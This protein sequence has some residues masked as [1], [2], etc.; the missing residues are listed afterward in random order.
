MKDLIK[1]YN[2]LYGQNYK[3]FNQKDIA[4]NNV[5]KDINI[6]QSVIDHSTKNGVCFGVVVY[7]ILRRLKGKEAK[8]FKRGSS[9]RGFSNRIIEM[10]AINYGW[11]EKR[12]ERCLSL[13][14]GQQDL[15]FLDITFHERD[16]AIG[17]G[18]FRDNLEEAVENTVLGYQNRDRQEERIYYI[19][20]T[21]VK[22]SGLTSERV[23]HAIAIHYRPDAFDGYNFRLIDANQGELRYTSLTHLIWH[24]LRQARKFNNTGRKRDKFNSIVWSRFSL[25]SLRIP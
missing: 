7:Y 23:G 14:L 1:Y 20:I 25:A 22:K 4:K 13:G 6:S 15:R 3:A 9:E 18:V 11:D 21:G 19:D 16:K 12:L 10:Q 5:T 8:Y 24:G 2:P 17:W